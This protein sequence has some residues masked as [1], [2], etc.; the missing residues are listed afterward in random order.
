S[1][2]GGASRS[3]VRGIKETSRVWNATEE[4]EMQFP[5]VFCRILRACHQ[6]ERVE[7]F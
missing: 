1:I 6:L 7:Y 5:L 2:R 4:G 3:F